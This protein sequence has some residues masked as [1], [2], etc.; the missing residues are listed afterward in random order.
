VAGN[1][2]AGTGHYDSACHSNQRH[3]HTA[4]VCKCC[5]FELRGWVPLC[6]MEL[7]V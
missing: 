4:T 1:V 2:A 3:H 6:K 7:S 5:V